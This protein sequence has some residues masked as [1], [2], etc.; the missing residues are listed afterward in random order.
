ML[1]SLGLGMGVIINISYKAG[2]NNYAQVASLLATVN[3]VTSLLATNTQYLRARKNCQSPVKFY[4]EKL[5]MMPSG[6]VSFRGENELLRQT[7]RSCK[8]FVIRK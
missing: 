3:L 5:L 1:Y 2:S 7:C 8:P 6:P 4:V